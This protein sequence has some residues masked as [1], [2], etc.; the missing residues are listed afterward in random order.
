MDQAPANHTI[1]NFRKFQLMWKKRCDKGKCTKEEACRAIIDEAV[2]IIK[3]L[4][5]PT[6]EEENMYHARTIN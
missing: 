1:Q 5:V 3:S 2:A 4:K 6:P